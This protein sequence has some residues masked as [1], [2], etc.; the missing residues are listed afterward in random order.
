ML[1]LDCALL[2][3]A[4]L[5]VPFRQFISPALGTAWLLA[6]S[7]YSRWRGFAK[8]ASAAEMC[9]WSCVL[10]ILLPVSVQI[11]S[12]TPAPLR[13][14]QL[15]RLDAWMGIN[16]HQFAGSLP[17]SIALILLIAYNLIAPFG[18]AAVVLPALRGQAEAS[19]RFILTVTLVAL[20]TCVIFAY[21][22]AIGP[23]AV[24][25]YT[26]S[27][28]QAAVE[29]TLVM[30]K[31][32]LPA[33]ISMRDAGIV[34]FPSFHAAFAISAAIALWSCRY[35]RLPALV[36]CILICISTISTGWHYVVDLFA[37]G[38]VALLAHIIVCRLTAT[39]PGESAPPVQFRPQ[40]EVARAS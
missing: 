38:I 31:S 20:L 23:W 27:P 39:V 11:A 3:L 13:D 37:G 21:V 29:R 26:P 4:H 18:A 36:L 30:L 7:R 40:A 5:S 14:I 1:A 19:Q 17:Q 34:S 15:A 6:L 16:V 25:G 9:A 33:T 24:Y 2:P 28:D 32:T 35:L 22:P 12:R 8:L 10:S